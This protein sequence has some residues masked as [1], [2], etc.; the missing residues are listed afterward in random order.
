VNQDPIGLAGGN[1]LY[2]FAPN[3]QSWADFLGL[4]STPVTI[5]LRF[6]TGMSR[7]EFQRKAEAL[8]KLGDAGKLVTIEKVKRD[9]SVT[10][11]YKSDLIKRIWRQYGTRNRDFANKLIERVK[12]RMQPDHVWELQLGGPDTR[13]NLKMLDTFTN[14]H[15]GTQQIWPQIRNLPTGT[16]IKIRIL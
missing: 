11:C 9:P 2:W 5:T 16:P 8:K 4:S 6:V 10:K 15:I 12:R 13:S 14:W 1:N 3:I 7:R